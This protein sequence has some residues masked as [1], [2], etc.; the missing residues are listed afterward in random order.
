NKALR[1]VAQ[2][3]RR[4]EQ[5]QFAQFAKPSSPSGDARNAT[6]AD[7]RALAAAGHGSVPL[8]EVASKQILRSYG[9]AVPEEVLV[10]SEAEAVEAARRIGYPVVLKAAA[11]Q[12]THK[13]DLGAVML[14]LANAD[15]VRSAYRR[16][17]SNLA[18]HGFT[19]ALDGLLVCRQV[20]GGLELV[21]GLQ[22]D[23][24]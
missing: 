6:V 23:P 17:A 5:E 7:V 8:N 9:L 18:R 1:A 15:D 21:L 14:H 19:G 2:V 10:A 13:S 11:A 12:L 4:A 3:A 24:E 20:R 16:I 22:R